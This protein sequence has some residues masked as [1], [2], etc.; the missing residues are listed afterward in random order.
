M[1]AFKTFFR[2]DAHQNAEFSEIV[3]NLP[4]SSDL[5]SYLDITLNQIIF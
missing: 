5:K 1:E 4:H 2:N 3:P